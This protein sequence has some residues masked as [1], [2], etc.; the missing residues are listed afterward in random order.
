MSFLASPRFLRNV[1]LA[2]A[3]SCLATGLAQVLFAGPLADLLALPAVLLLAT[4]WFMI[5]Y[6]LLAAFVATRQPVPPG[7]VWLF[8][9]GNFSWAIGCVAVAFGAWFH[10]SA[11]GIVWVLAQ[12]VTVAVLAELQWA[13]VRRAT[14]AGWA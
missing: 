10:P 14:P 6:A 1:L 12:A 3:A 5:V 2:D 8:V 7:W 9:A 11:L 4:G 13:G